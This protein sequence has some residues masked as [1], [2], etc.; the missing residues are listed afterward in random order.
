MATKNNAG[1]TLEDIPVITSKW[2]ELGGDK[3]E[4]KEIL[5]QIKNKT[6]L[7]VK[8]DSCQIENNHLLIR[9]KVVRQDVID[10]I[11]RMVELDNNK[12]KDTVTIQLSKQ[13]VG[14]MDTI[15]SCCYNS[16]VGE[17]LPA[18]NQSKTLAVYLPTKEDFESAYRMLARMGV[19]ISVDTI[20]DKIETNANDSN[21]LLKDN[22]R[23]ITEKNIEIWSKKG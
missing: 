12:N 14:L 2:V 5:L 22:W 8:K 10:E 16:Y 23:I 19:E 3:K 1:L 21:T 6:V 15:L 4:R 17:D 13:T 7:R 20:L 18:G 11:A 9:K